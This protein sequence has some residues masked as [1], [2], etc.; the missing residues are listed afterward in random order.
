[1][2][3]LE[4]P[5]HVDAVSVRALALYI[6]AIRSP[7]LG[8]TIREPVVSSARS[9]QAPPRSSCCGGPMARADAR[10]RPVQK[11]CRR[12]APYLFRIYLTQAIE[13]TEDPYAFGSSL[14]DVRSFLI[15]RRPAFRVGQVLGAQSLTVDGVSGVRFAVWAPSIVHY[16]SPACPIFLFIKT[17]GA[18]GIIYWT[19]SGCAFS[20][21]TI[22]FLTGSRDGLRSVLGLMAL[23]MGGYFTICSFQ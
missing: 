3:Q 4:L 16:S 20:V 19:C 6:N 22:Y 15:Q 14:G 8:R 10:E 9:C 5:C 21:I 7:R 11:L 2:H 12:S 13:R 1:M 23:I 17:Q 18:N